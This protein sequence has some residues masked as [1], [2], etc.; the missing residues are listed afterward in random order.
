MFPQNYD[1]RYRVISN[2]LSPRD[3]PDHFRFAATGVAVTGVLMLPFVGYFQRQFKFIAP[4]MARVST[5]MF[6]GGV[7]ALICACFVAP[8]HTHDVFGFRR[9]H[10]FFGRSAA[11][12]LAIGMLC[13]CWCAWKNR[14]TNRL[15]AGLFWAWSTVTLLPLGGA[16]GSECLLLLTRLQPAWASPIHRVLRNSVF[17]HLGF[18]EWMG[19]ASVFTFLAAAVFLTPSQTRPAP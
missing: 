10:E 11:G 12:F 1:W 7:V 2:L 14:R 16:S 3:N 8:Q 17:W 5:I 6:T 19:A 4:R 13:S 15:A 18:W 9:V